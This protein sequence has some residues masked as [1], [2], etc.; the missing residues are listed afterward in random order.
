MLRS[1]ASFRLAFAPFLIGLA[2]A[3]GCKNKKPPETDP[4][5]Q[6]PVALG[7][8]TVR[9]STG[10]NNE[11][12]QITISGSGFASGAKVFIGDTP[13]R[14]VAV[15][16]GSSI[17]ATVPEGLT[18]NEYV[19]AVR[20]PDGKEATLPRGFTVTEG[21]PDLAA[22]CRIDPVYFNFDDSTLT[23]EAR[24]NLGSTVD[25]LK[26]RKVNRVRVE[27]HADERGST[28]YNLALGQRRAETVR[29]Y[30]SKVGYSSGDITTISYGEERPASTGSDESAWSQNRRAEIVTVE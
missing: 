6:G 26:A 12:T 25:C 27:G 16:G 20:N 4:T 23:E 7:L 8:Q 14:N 19:V 9:P 10:P 3:T 2:L 30:L 18:P 28:D 21:T 22:T 15:N 29:S 5:E 13:A 1:R 11:P 17:S 24:G